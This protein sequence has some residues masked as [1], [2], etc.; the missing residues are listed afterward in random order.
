MTELH[1]ACAADAAYVSH[2]AA[3]LHS[4]ITHGGG[5][6]VVHYLRGPEFPASKAR[7]L[8]RMLA[9]HGSELVFHEILDGQLGG[10]PLDHRFGPAMW[11]RIF[12]PELLPDISQILYLDVDTL[13]VDSLDPLWETPLDGCYVAAVRNVFMEYHRHRAPELGIE[14]A[15]YFNSGVLMLNLALMRTEDFAGRLI[16]LVR[17]RGSELLWPDQ[18]ALNLVA[19]TRWS[20]LH[21]RW[22][23]MNSF[24]TRP[25][26]A[27]EAFGP[28]ALAEAIA[29]PAIRHFE[30]PGPNKP[31]HALYQGPDQQLYRAH[32]QAS[33]WPRVRLEG[34]SPLDRLRR[35]LGIGEET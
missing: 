4:A 32:R 27:A 28:E 30:G 6:V 11:Y 1:L 35:A 23:V 10:L 13:V 24:A 20:R 3:M 22:N 14:E 12:L 8:E 29:H 5:P 19:G 18:D 2:S 15:D 26:L 34:R 31:W 21:P 33:P 9:G 16:D 25:Q 7:K 17:R